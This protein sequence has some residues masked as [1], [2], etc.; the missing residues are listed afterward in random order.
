MSVGLGEIFNISCRETC[1]C[2][3]DGLPECHDRCVHKPSTNLPPS[4]REVSDENDP[5][6]LQ[7][8]CKGSNNFFEDWY[9]QNID[10]SIH[11]CCIIYYVLFLLADNVVNNMPKILVKQ[12]SQTTLTV[13]WDD[14]R[15]PS[16]HSEYI[17]EYRRLAFDSTQNWTKVQVCDASFMVVSATIFYFPFS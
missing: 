3:T 14:F 6:C 12:K 17:L 1:I 9:W 7:L 15:L 13:V 16:Y 11:A 2:Y 5:C 10:Y 4:C 8:K